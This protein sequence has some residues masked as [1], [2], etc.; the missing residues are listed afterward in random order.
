VSYQDGR[1]VLVTGAASGIGKATT[2]EFAALGA[3]VS[4]VDLD[5]PHGT[6]DEC[7]DL[8]GHCL[9]I[10][11]DVSVG[12]QIR[13]AVEDTVDRFGRL[14]GVVCNAAIGYPEPFLEMSEESWDRVFDVN[15]G[16][17]FLLVQAALP[18]IQTSD[19]ASVV[20][21]SS[22]AG[23]TASLTNGAHYTCSKYAL[24]GLTRHLAAELG[25]TGVRV[26][27]VCP[28]PTDHTAALLENSDEAEREKIIQN[29][30][31]RRLALPR[32]VARVITF[33]SGES[34][35]HMHGSIVDVNGGLY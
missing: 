3:N 16:G 1:T 25:G 10:T 14:D 22:I 4:A 21:V 23:R 7:A 12:Q 27:C 13:G 28:G 18:H 5:T 29:T 30:P 35:S 8:P 2:V 34:A 24:V 20:I 17:A 19:V 31:L 11:A 33:L 15:L 26:N 6:I 9:G 32:D